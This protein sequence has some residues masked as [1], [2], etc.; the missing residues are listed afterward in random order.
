MFV[1]ILDDVKK[2]DDVNLNKC[3][4]RPT[5][6]SFQLNSELVKL[7]RTNRIKSDE[8]NHSDVVIQIDKDL[9]K[10]KIIFAQEHSL[11]KT[12]YKDS[13]KCIL[14]PD[15][16]KTSYISIPN[17]VIESITKKY[18]LKYTTSRNSP[19]R[20]SFNSSTPKYDRI[21]LEGIETDSYSRISTCIFG[22]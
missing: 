22:Y 21:Y 12:P 1:N 3:F 20:K 4:I 7:L 15:T 17:K 9:K 14:Y 11:L 13:F 18:G 19:V 16:S 10:I 8:I 6:S 2:E 5:T